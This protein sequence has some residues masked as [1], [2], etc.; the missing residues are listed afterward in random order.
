MNDWGFTE[1]TPS[2]AST[3][4]KGQKNSP[5][6][7]RIS[8]LVA[9]PPD[10]IAPL[11]NIF[12]SDARFSLVA[13][14]TSTEDVRVKMAVKPAVVL[15]HAQVFESFEAFAQVLGNYDGSLY[16]ILP[17][18]APPSVIESVR[19]M[20]PTR[21]VISGDPNLPELAGR[22]YGAVS[23]DRQLSLTGQGYRLGQSGPRSAMVGW[24]C[25]AVWSLQGG[26]GRSTIA[27]ALALEAAERRLPTLLVGLGVPDVVPLR[28]NFD[29]PEPNL[30]TWS[31][32]PTSE[33]LK[34]S[35]RQFD[36]LDVLAGFPNQRA[37]DDYAPIALSAQQGLP[38]LASAAAHAGYAVVVLD[39]SAPEMAAPAISA[40]NTLILTA[41]PTPD[42]LLAVGEA[43]RM[44]G[45]FMNRQH[46]IPLEGMHLVL[47]RVRDTMLAPD[48]FMRSL[49][50]MPDITPP[51]AAVIPDD[52]R[53]DVART[54]F[55]PAYNFSEP[56]RQ[57]MKHIGD[58]LFAPPPGLA[59]V[60]KAQQGR[61]SKVWRIGPLRIKR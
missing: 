13:T 36:V 49:G 16:V 10:H 34:V 7:E 56:L 19:E 20:S 22:I 26:T 2:T 60:Q 6:A 23:A 5:T 58:I 59:A 40:A 46:S 32:V 53:I 31:S 41:L 33:Q 44:A 47:N 18:K 1:T 21:D 61:P 55:R 8:I 45:D 48:E 24:R 14:A 37:L 12:R 52:P 39:V 15:A 51:L 57:A 4:G 25:I 28:L 43:S 17:E 27:T 35:V 42:G 50:R 9:A 11:T 30:L 54:Q 38:A 3:N 29:G